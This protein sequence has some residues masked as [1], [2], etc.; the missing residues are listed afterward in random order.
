[1]N[2]ARSYPI[3][4]GLYYIFPR[5]KNNNTHLRARIEEMICFLYQAESNLELNYEINA[6][7]NIFECSNF[8]IL[9]LATFK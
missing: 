6:S 9:K 2:R 4:G 3:L 7:L 5:T 1:M 8:L